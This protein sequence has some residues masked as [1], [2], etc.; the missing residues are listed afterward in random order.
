MMVQFATLATCLGVSGQI[1]A[2]PLCN[3][4]RRKGVVF[5]D[6]LGD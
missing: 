3:A 4:P 1:V 6:T 5:S 2:K